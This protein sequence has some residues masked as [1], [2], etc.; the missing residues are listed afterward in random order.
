MHNIF[1]CWKEMGTLDNG[2]MFKARLGMSRYQL[3]KV[4]DAMIRCS[5]EE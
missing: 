3:M 2:E 5:T 4:V 1:E